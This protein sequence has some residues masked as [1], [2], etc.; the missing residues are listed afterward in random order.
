MLQSVALGFALFF[1]GWGIAFSV[2]IVCVPALLD[3]EKSTALD[4]AKVTIE[5]LTALAKPKRTPAEEHNYQTAKTALQKLPE[6][7]LPLLRHIYSVERLV[8]P[9]FQIVL[10]FG[11][12]DAKAR[13]LSFQCHVVGLLTRDVKQQ[14]GGHETT[15]AITP[16]MKSALEELLYST[17]AT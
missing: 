4:T 2:S 9:N 8:F 11:M 1:A 13:E 6:E 5:K 12:P 17:P 3:A 7:V 10:P 16:G 14:G 15:F